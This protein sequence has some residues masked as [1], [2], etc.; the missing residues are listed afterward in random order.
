M[1][2]LTLPF[3][4]SANHVWKHRRANH[5]AYLSQRAKM[6]RAEVVATLRSLGVQ[7]LLG[8]LRVE[9]II[10]P[11]DQRKRDLDNLLKSLLDALQHGR[12]FVDDSQISHL[13]IIRREPMPPA[14]ETKVRIWEQSE[15]Q[16]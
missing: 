4:V 14:G 2:E 8:P 12:A 7:P 6:F 10:H 13:V 15:Q 16:E 3:P 1:I 5:R 11:P 9:I